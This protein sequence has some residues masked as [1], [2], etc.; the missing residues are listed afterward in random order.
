M[1]VVSVNY[2]VCQPWIYEL[3]Y[4][5][6]GGFRLV[7]LPACLCPKLNNF[8]STRWGN[9]VVVKG[10]LNLVNW[11]H[12]KVWIFFMH[13]LFYS[14]PNNIESVRVR[15]AVAKVALLIRYMA[16][17]PL[18]DWKAAI[19]TWDGDRNDWKGRLRC[20]PACLPVSE[21]QQLFRNKVVPC[22]CC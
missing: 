14:K 17:M 3:R 12:V 18:R 15:R 16:H 13:S 22:C 8:S 19:L 6:S 10:T 2:Y 9:A 20:L 21:A 5:L 7:C 11:P 4:R 1:A